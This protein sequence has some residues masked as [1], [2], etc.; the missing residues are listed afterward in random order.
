MPQSK[1]KLIDGKQQTYL[2]LATA[3]RESGLTTEEI[4]GKLGVLRQ[5]MERSIN[6]KSF[7][8]EILYELEKILNRKIVFSQF[9]TSDKHIEVLQ[10]QIETLQEVIKGFADRIPRKK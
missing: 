1:N 4:A 2:T 6:R 9:D 3:I 5:S 7:R 8:L 10:A